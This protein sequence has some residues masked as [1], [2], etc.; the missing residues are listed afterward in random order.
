MVEGEIV[1]ITWNRRMVV[2]ALIA[3]AVGFMLEYG[4][5]SQ[6]GKLEA[7]DWSGYFRIVVPV[8]CRVVSAPP[9]KASGHLT[10]RPCLRRPMG[11]SWSEL[12]IAR[13]SRGAGR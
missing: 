4:V 13:R 8:Q 1:G 2:T 6:T 11:A 9:C 5:S 3:A 12:V 10:R 7:W